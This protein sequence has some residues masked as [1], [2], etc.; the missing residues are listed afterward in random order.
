[1]PGWPFTTPRVYDFDTGYVAVPTS[2]TAITTAIVYMA[3]QRFT[4]TTSS[5]RTVSLVDTAGGAILSEYPIGPHG[6]IPS[7]AINFEPSTG[8]KWQASDTGVVGK[9]WGWTS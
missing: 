4:N 9:L 6:S 2:L 5:A 1:M 8:L 7:P 3:G